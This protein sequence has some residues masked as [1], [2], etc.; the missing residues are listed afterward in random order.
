MLRPKQN[1]MLRNLS[2][3]ALHVGL[4]MG[5]IQQRSQ[6]EQQRLVESAESQNY[7]RADRIEA[8]EIKALSFLETIVQADLPLMLVS[9]FIVLV[10]IGLAVSMPELIALM[11]MRCRLNERFARLIWGILFVCII[12]VGGLTALSVFDIELMYTLQLIGF[13]GIWLSYGFG[14]EISNVVGGLMMPFL[15]FI[16]TGKQV[17]IEGTQGVVEHVTLRHT[18]LIMLVNGKKQRAWVPNH[19][20]SQQIT[21]EDIDENTIAPSTKGTFGF[22]IKNP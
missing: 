16:E 1:I 15:S 18:S 17:T 20:W 5:A 19:V 14:T 12:A 6:Q 8:A 7:W 2:M 10:T 3:F 9:F 22:R 21:F 11:L 4:T 13:F